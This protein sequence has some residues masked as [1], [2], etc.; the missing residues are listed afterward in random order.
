MQKKQLVNRLTN[1]ERMV[2]RLV[3]RGLPNKAIARS[4]RLNL[5]S[6]ESHTYHLHKKLNIKGRTLLAIKL[7]E[8]EVDSQ[9]FRM[10]YK[11]KI[12][13]LCYRGMDSQEIARKIG[14]KPSYAYQCSR[15][16]YLE[17]R[18]ATQ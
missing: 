7:L 4:L 14:C 5:R 10:T 6:V 15:K 11:Q 8:L 16:F 17:Q 12:A 9:P 1:T 3:A 13:F 2:G 18:Q